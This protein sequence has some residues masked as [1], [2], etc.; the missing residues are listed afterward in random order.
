MK[1]T[2]KQ[3]SEIIAFDAKARLDERYDVRPYGSMTINVPIDVRRRDGNCPIPVFAKDVHEWFAKEKASRKCLRYNYIVA[4][5]ARDVKKRDVCVC[6][7][8]VKLDKKYKPCVKMVAMTDLSEEN[9]VIRYRDLGYHFLAGWHV[10]W[11]NS[12]WK[13]KAINAWIISG[14]KGEF[15]A[16]K[17][18]FGIGLTF[19]WHETINADVLN[20]TRYRYCSY[21][22]N[23][24][25]GLLDWLMLYRNNPQVELLAKAGLYRLISPSGLRVLK[26][27]KT[28]E[29][30]RKNLSE[31]AAASKRLNVT[32]MIYCVSHRTTP[33]EAVAHFQF[34]VDMQRYLPRYVGWWE[35]ESKRR[36]FRLDYERVR[37]QIAKWGVSIQEYCRYITEAQDYG[38]DLKNEGTLYPPVRDGRKTFMERL[39]ALE[40][41]NQKRHRREERARKKEERERRK[42]ME[43]EELEREKKEQEYAKK[44]MASRLREI[45]GFQKRADRVLKLS[46]AGYTCVLAK[47]QE[48]LRKEGKKMNNCVGGG[49]YGK[50]IVRGDTLILMFRDK[51]GRC[52]CDAQI[53]RSNWRI[54]QCYSRGNSEAPK[55]IQDMAMAI[56]AELRKHHLENKKSNKFPKLNEKTIERHIR[57]A[58]A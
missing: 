40:S 1:L 25:I 18:K 53:D 39:E 45:A 50:G 49:T 51:K 11:D 37:K 41:E 29:Y 6:H 10:Y 56:A 3:E 5:K 54:R 46:G 44:V 19:P 28:R 7:V 52:W 38:L 12:D 9:P 22:P 23:H 4:N 8:A 34:V 55:E 43:A 36:S 15:A 33:D 42:K 58:V 2:K 14:A 20:D 21:T 47:S 27:P 32:E 13:D 17:Y 35:K 26:S 16:A 48:E 31:L 57:R 24:G 30:V